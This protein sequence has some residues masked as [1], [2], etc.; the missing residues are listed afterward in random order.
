MKRFSLIAA[1]CTAALHSAAFGQAP[2]TDL[3]AKPEDLEYYWPVPPVVSAPAQAAPSDAVVLFDGRSLDRWQSVKTHGPAEWALADGVM[4]VAPGTGYIATKQAFGDI[5]LHLEFREPTPPHGD[6]QARGNSGV[7][8]MGLYELQVLDCYD[9]PTY[10]N[11]QVASLYKQYA[12]LV[13]ASR[14]AGQWQTYDCIWIA[15]RFTA[16]GRVAS[17]ARLTV[18]HNGVLAQY[19]VP[20]KGPTFY[21]SQPRYSPHAAQLPLVLQE[22]HDA[23]SYRNIWV[24]ELNLPDYSV[25]G[26]VTAP[27]SRP[28]S[29]L[30]QIQADGSFRLN[31]LP[32]HDLPLVAELTKW[33]RKDASLPVDI[34]S[35]VAAPTDRLS[36]AVAA[37]KQAG[38]T[39]IQIASP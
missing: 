36:A 4:T 30:V 14:P 8:F 13:N 31:R 29:I 19:N 33:H 9:N 27:A 6:S 12:P 15:P 20:V 32:L 1:V 28:G 7:L 2:A 17:P 39:R 35:D 25:D 16:D 34:R 18:F 37:C 26:T 5:Q 23:V 21:N 22:H 38:F 24:R 11:G 10:V 3:S